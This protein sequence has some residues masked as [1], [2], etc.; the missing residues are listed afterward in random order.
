MPESLTR[1]E[2]AYVNLW[3]V[4]LHVG[5]ASGFTSEWRPASPRNRVRLQVGIASGI[6]SEY[7]AGISRNLHWSL[8]NP[9]TASATASS[10]PCQL[11]VDRRDQLGRL[12]IL[13]AAL[14]GQDPALS[15]PR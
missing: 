5:M 4:R 9:S 8:C 1:R 12:D 3:G 10:G 11:I 2:G 7:L 14:R 6:A 15:S 13:E